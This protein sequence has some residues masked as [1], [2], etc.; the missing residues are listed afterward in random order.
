MNNYFL[1]AL[2]M[3][4]EYFQ[5]SAANNYAI[6]E[7][8][9]RPLEAITDN[10]LLFVEFPENPT[11]ALGVMGMLVCGRDALLHTLLREGLLIS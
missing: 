7:F 6:P 8:I 4:V 2:G 5:L 3:L 9:S 11:K 1:P 10:V